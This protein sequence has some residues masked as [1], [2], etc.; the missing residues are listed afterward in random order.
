MNELFNQFSAGA[1]AFRVGGPNLKERG[2][3][4]FIDFSPEKAWRA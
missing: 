2:P 4:F 3:K 1:R